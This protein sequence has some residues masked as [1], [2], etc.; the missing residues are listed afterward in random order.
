MAALLPRRCPAIPQRFHIVEQCDVGAQ[1]RERSE[2][3]RAVAL[4]L[5]HVREFL[6]ARDGDVP[7]ASL[8]RDRLE[9]QIPSE[10]L[11]S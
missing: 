2:Q 1:R 6:G 10:D 7:I 4:F 3:E 11:R 8:G 9:V 5:Q